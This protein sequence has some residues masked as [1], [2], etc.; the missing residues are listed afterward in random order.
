MIFSSGKGVA[1]SRRR[2][3]G[4]SRRG[5]GHS[6]ALQS[7]KSFAGLFQF[8]SQVPAS[9]KFSVVFVQSLLW[10]PVL[11]G[12][13]LFCVM[14]HFAVHQALESFLR[15]VQVIKGW[16]SLSRATYLL[17]S[18]LIKRECCTGLTLWMPASSL[19]CL[20]KSL[21]G[22]SLQATTFSRGSIEVGCIGQVISRKALDL[23]C[24]FMLLYITSASR[25]HRS[26]KRY[27]RRHKER[28]YLFVSY[29]RPRGSIRHVLKIW[30]LTVESVCGKRCMQA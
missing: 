1:S 2:I 4:L 25:K 5:I 17:D 19:I 27:R 13:L 14:L 11:E 22:L 29:E 21:L 8:A 28:P 7:F 10:M 18:V 9:V 15:A 16:A 20:E 24:E 6:M 12:V 26:V 3:R 30:T 23:R